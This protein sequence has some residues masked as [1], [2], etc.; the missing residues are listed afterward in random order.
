MYDQDPKKCEETLMDWR[1]LATP[2]LLS[3]ADDCALC[4]VDLDVSCLDALDEQ[5]LLSP[6]ECF[7][8][9]CW[10]AAVRD[11]V[12]SPVMHRRSRARSFKCDYD[13]AFPPPLDRE[14]PG[15]FERTRPLAARIKLPLEVV[16]T[17]GCPIAEP[18]GPTDVSP[19]RSSRTT[20]PLPPL[21]LVHHSIHPSCLKRNPW[22]ISRTLILKDASC[23][24]F[25]AYPC[26][27]GQR[28]E[29]KL[30]RGLSNH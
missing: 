22:R 6:V 27:G 17:S 5:L 30:S 24:P 23:Y 3:V 25:K 9:L 15:S 14:Y 18:A 29:I 28:S 20:F 26:L 16:S 8:E 10:A 1:T 7:S 12:T 2:G 13:R 4:G 21:P 11:E 19:S